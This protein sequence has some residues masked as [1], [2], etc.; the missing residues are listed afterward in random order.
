MTRSE[1]TCRLT[2]VHP[3]LGF[4]VLISPPAEMRVKR[5]ETLIA[6]IEEL[7]REPWRVRERLTRTIEAC[8]A[9]E[10]LVEFGRRHRGR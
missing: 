9:I 4:R 10:K 5:A 7:L 3:V 2:S 8:E 6:R 1:R